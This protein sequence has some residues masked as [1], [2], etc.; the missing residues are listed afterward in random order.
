MVFK[1]FEKDLLDFLFNIPAQDE[2][3]SWRLESLVMGKIREIDMNQFED[4]IQILYHCIEQLL[5]AKNLK[6]K[7]RLNRKEKST[8]N[9]L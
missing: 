7:Y 4:V 5:K 6:E 1:H 2:F 3:R 8:C 9:Y